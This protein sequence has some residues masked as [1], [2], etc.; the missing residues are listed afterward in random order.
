MHPE[1]ERCDVLATTA[2]DGGN[3]AIDVGFEMSQNTDNAFD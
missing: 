3:L 2:A 1:N